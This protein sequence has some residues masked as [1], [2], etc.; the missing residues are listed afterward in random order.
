M[1]HLFK[2]VT[3]I[4]FLAACIS[5]SQKKE[6]PQPVVETDYASYEQKNIESGKLSTGL[7][8]Q[9]LD[10][11]AFVRILDGYDEEI[12]ID[13]CPIVAAADFEKLS[14]ESPTFQNGEVHYQ[15]LV[16]LNSRGKERLKEISKTSTNRFLPIVMNDTIISAPH[17]N[18]PLD[19]DIFTI[20]LRNSDSL[21][22]YQKLIDKLE[23][24]KSK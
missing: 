16:K 23:A 10:S 9:S 20:S 11:T 17:L 12:Y 1:H 4:L 13:P 8:R 15:I 2:S 5:C 18:L 6:Q 14:I 22:E 24:E 7:Y 3:C 19:G 21:E